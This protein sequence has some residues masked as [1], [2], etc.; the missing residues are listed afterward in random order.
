MADGIH[1]KHRERV[2]KE[3]LSHSINDSSSAHKIIEALLFYSIPRKDTNETAHLLVN[4]FGSITGILEAEP[5]ELMKIPGI[6]ENTVALFKLI[7]ATTKAYLNE[8]DVPPKMF[9]NR[10]QVC[11]FIKNKYLGYTREVFSVMS[12]DSRGGF[13]GFDF[14]SV[15]DISAVGVTSRM[16]VEV[17]I[18][19]KATC[20]ILAHNH[21]GGNALPSQ[22]DIIIT[23]M[24]SEALSH[25]EVKLIDHVIVCDDDYVSLGISE[26]FKKIFTK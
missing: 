10:D 3:I 7:M 17:A 6:G 4:R 9:D 25:M 8:K 16:V 19:R 14:L 18:K 24:M 23:E 2:R 13:V 5:E 15:G 22:D 26:N 12:F 11:R 21:P 1:S 20:V